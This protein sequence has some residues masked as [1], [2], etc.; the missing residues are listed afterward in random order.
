MYTTHAHPWGA[1]HSGHPGSLTSHRATVP[2]NSEVKWNRWRMW[3]MKPRSRFQTGVT[4]G[5][6]RVQKVGVGFPWRTVVNPAAPHEWEDAE[7]QHCRQRSQFS[8]IAA[9]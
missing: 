3:V 1:E 5:Y 7:A 4:L 2:N 6:S 8:P 9:E